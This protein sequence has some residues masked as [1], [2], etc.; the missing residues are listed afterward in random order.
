MF[1]ADEIFQRVASTAEHAVQRR[2]PARQCG[3]YRKRRVGDGDQVGTPSHRS[4][5]S[6][7]QLRRREIL[8][9]ADEIGATCRTGFCKAEG[10]GVGQVSGK[11]HATAVAE[12]SERQQ[13]SA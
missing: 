9:V 1:H 10:N 12:T 6:R 13:P 4:T 2:A 5:Q 3:Q 7:N 11:Q 8:A